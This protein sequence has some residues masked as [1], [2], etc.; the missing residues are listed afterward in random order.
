EIPPTPHFREMAPEVDLRGTPLYVTATRRD[1]PAPAGAPR[2]ACVNSI[3]LGGVVTHH[4]LEEA[5]ARPA[6]SA[7]LREGQLLVLSA[8]TSTALETATANLAAWLERHPEAPLADVAWTLQTGR[9]A[10]EHR[11]VLLCTHTVEAS[12]ILRQPAAGLLHTAAIRRRRAPVALVLPA[13]RAEALD[14]LRAAAAPYR[15]EPTFR[16][17]VERGCGLLR[18]ALARRLREALLAAGPLAEMDADEAELALFLFQYA[19]GRLWQ[20]WLGEPQAVAGEGVG[21]YAVACLTGAATLEDVLGTL[22][23][24]GVQPGRFAAA[25]G[26]PADAPDRIVLVIGAG[27][28]EGSKE[29]AVR[30]LLETAALTVAA[31]PTAGDPAADRHPL[32]LLGQIWLAGAAVD[33]SAFHAGEA[34]HRLALPTYPFERRR[35]WVDAGKDPAEAMQLLGAVGSLGLELKA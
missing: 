25:L 34:R 32:A 13:V 23:A 8:R 31:L 22:A 17:E 14:S 20:G 26:M 33:W 30:R 7:P 10:L 16:E 12:E 4:I 18:P 9:R 15:Q 21:E 11:R 1:F 3:G 27:A 6:S 29:P 5:P 28:P 2:R 35:Y 19:L 24:R